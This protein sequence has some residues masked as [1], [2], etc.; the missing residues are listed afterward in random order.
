MNKGVKIR[1]FYFLV[2]MFFKS[3]IYSIYNKNKN[4]SS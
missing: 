3:E 4:S 1:E 2:Y